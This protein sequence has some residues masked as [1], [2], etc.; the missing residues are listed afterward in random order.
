MVLNRIKREGGC[1]LHKGN[2]KTETLKLRKNKNNNQT[3]YEYH[4]TDACSL[5]ILP[6]QNHHRGQSDAINDM[7]GYRR[8]PHAE[9]RRLMHSDHNPSVASQAIVLEKRLR[10][11]FRSS[12]ET[13]LVET[14]I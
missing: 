8:L 9:A 2:I 4:R 7:K 14:P 6:C 1:E 13:T 5:A 12:T 11:L 10:Y 3:Y